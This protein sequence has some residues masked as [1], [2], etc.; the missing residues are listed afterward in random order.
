MNAKYGSLLDSQSERS[1]QDSEIK[2]N[3]S[4]NKIEQSNDQSNQ[5]RTFQNKHH[6]NKTDNSEKTTSG[7]SE[8]NTAKTSSNTTSEANEKMNRENLYHWGATRE[9]MDIIRKRNKSPETR[10]LVERREAL[11]KPGTMRRRYDTQSQR[12]IFTPSRPNKRSRE[13]IAEIDAELTQR[14]H[15]IGGGYR[16][17]QPEEE[18]EPEAPE[19]GELQ[20]EQ[21]TVDTEEDN[22]KMRGDNLPIVDLSKYHTDGK[23][24]H[25][26]QINH[27]VGKITE[28]K[29]LTEENIKKA[30]FNF[31]L[32][33]KTLI[34]KTAIDPEMTR[35]RDSMR[36]EEK[37]T[38]PEGYR[39]V[40]DKLSIRWGFILCLRPNCRSNRL[41]KK[42][43]RDTTL[44]SFW[45]N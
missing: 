31:M 44:R 5:N 43:D 33:L 37:D 23:E 6:V 19:E 17:L 8:I 3:Q 16:P 14:A 21:N 42:T 34:S 18:E 41:T 30:E 11:A 22:V 10:R 13:E 12:M 24:A 27:I 29:K 38:A 7:Q 45:D 20:T 32:D 40:F 2:Q 28:N 9:I 15:R 4:E 39:P 25:Y 35:V 1:N 26:I 36:R